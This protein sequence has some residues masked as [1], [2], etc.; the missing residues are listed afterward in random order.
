ML[1]EWGISTLLEILDFE[2]GLLASMAFKPISTLLEI[3]AGWRAPRRRG[4][5]QCYFN[6]S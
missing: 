2:W 6:P 3:L 4:F 1:P 5:R